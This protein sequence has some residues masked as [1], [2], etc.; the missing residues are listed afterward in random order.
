MV[1]IFNIKTCAK[2]A[3]LTSMEVQ[4]IGTESINRKVAGGW[5]DEGLGFD[6]D[7]ILVFK[8]TRVLWMEG[9]DGRSHVSVLSATQ[10]YT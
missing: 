4:V 7:R 1:L 5:R 2:D 9:G 6:G 10:S 3:D 8:M